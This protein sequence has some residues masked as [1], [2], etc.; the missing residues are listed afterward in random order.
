MQITWF[1]LFISL[2]VAFICL[3]L[4]VD[5][6][7]AKALERHQS[8]ISEYLVVRD[9]SIKKA[10][11]KALDKVTNQMFSGYNFINGR[12]DE[13]EEKINGGRENKTNN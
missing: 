13:Q 6:K 7:I 1:G 9:A 8:I 4:I 2:A 11:D 3:A 5:Y 10:V 12:I